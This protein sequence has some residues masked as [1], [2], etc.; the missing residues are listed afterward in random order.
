M[1]SRGIAV[2]FLDHGTRRRWG[3]SITPRPLFTTGKDPVPTVQEAGW[4]LGPAWTGAENL[5]RTGIQ[6]ADH[7]ARSQSLY[8]LRYPALWTSKESW[9]IPGK[10]KRFVS[11]L[12]YFAV[13]LSH[14]R[15]T[16]GNTSVPR[17]VP[18]ELFKC[19]VCVLTRPCEG[20]FGV[21][22]IEEAGDFSKIFKLTLVPSPDYCSIGTANE[23]SRAWPRT[24][25]TI[26]M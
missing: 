11:S 17:L 7:P 23:A 18:P 24:A 12:S 26:E 3:V 19:A 2:P 9:L 25:L 8:W 16:A 6:S 10:V 4:A 14:F 21:Q 13:T 1:G 5:A 22:F 20:W 15:S